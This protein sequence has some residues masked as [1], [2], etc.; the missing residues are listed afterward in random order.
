MALS[1]VFV[2]Q[3][4]TVKVRLPAIQSCVRSVILIGVTTM[5]L[6]RVFAVALFVSVSCAAWA[7]LHSS[8]QPEQL[9]VV[10]LDAAARPIVGARLTIGD[11]VRR[12]DGGGFVN[13]AVPGS[14]FVDVSAPG[15]VPKRVDLPP[16]DHR[17]HL[18]A[19][20]R[21]PGATPGSLLSDV[22]RRIRAARGRIQ[23]TAASSA[24]GSSRNAHPIGRPAANSETMSACHRY[25]REVA[26]AL[27]S[28]RA[29][30]GLGLGPHLQAARPAA[31][32]VDRVRPGSAGPRLRRRRHRL[33]S[34]RR[35]SEALD[36]L[37]SRRRR[38]RAWCEPELEWP[39][40]QT[41]R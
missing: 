18:E 5:L 41:R 38:R 40:A 9:N 6:R 12:T 22:A 37:R 11:E 36:R 32:L 16:G 31:M 15:Y 14:V 24:H 10:V 21:A 33:P 17:V 35:R 4:L 28:G 2:G 1:P 8:G 23:P 27:A 3:H 39:A 26:T 29:A 25:T 34:A 20:S 30:S 13:F 7:P 19:M